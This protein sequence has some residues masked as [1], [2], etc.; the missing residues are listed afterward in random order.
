MLRKVALG[1][2]GIG[3][4]VSGSAMASSVSSTPNQNVTAQTATQASAQAATIIGGAISNA[5]GGGGGGGAA[6]VT[7]YLNSRDTGRNAGAVD[8]PFGIWVQGAYT[9]VDNGQTGAAFDGSIV[10][11]L[12]GFDYKLND[13]LVIGISG[14]YETIDIDTNSFSS[15]RGSLENDGMGIAPYIGFKLT[16]Q[17]TADLTAGYSW[18]SYDS[19]RSGNAVH[20]SFD[21][22]RWFAN[23]SLNGTYSVGSFRLLPKVGVLYMEE[24]QDGYRET[25]GTSVAGN[26]IT[27]GRAYAGG[28]VGY[29]MGTMMPYLKLIG[30]WDFEHPDSLAI[31]NGTF[32]NDEDFGAQVG[33]G[34][35]F[36]SAGPLSGTVET[37]YNSLGRDDLDVWSVLG[38]LRLRF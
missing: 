28:R 12:A 38:R 33:V 21:A 24:D 31:G 25:N 37:S 4:F 36:F 6:N 18:L 5:I 35:D 3:M 7:S 19:S 27:L 14:T 34:V 9:N 22:T 32:T 16:N 1:L 29:A 11:L 13:R 2:V 26:T 15:G 8:K 23:G 10:N 17:W 30:E 20:G